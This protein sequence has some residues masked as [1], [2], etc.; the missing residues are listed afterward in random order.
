M[1]GQYLALNFVQ[2]SVPPKLSVQRQHIVL[3]IPLQSKSWFIQ[4]HKSFLGDTQ[5]G[6]LLCQRDI[7]LYNS[8]LGN[9]TVMFNKCIMLFQQTLE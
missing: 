7:I 3:F 4:C 9:F 8:H 5:K 1:Y 2:H 6:N